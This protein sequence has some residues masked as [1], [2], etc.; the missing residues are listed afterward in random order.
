LAP[1]PDS[2]RRPTL[3]V[4]V[5]RNKEV[6]DASVTGITTGAFEVG[7]AHYDEA[8]PDLLGPDIVV[9]LEALRVADHFR[10]ANH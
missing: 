1:G 10:F 7:I 2:L 3:G 6:A 4:V 8:P 5:R 9:S